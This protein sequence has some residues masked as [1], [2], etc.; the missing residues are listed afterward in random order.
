[1]AIFKLDDKSD[2]IEAVANEEL[3]N[4]NK[5]LLAED[6]LIIAQGKVQNDRFSGGLRM[7]VQ[8]VWSLAAARARFGRHLMLSDAGTAGLIHDLV[9]RFPPRVV[10]TEEGG[11]RKLGLPV[12]VSVLAEP[13]GGQVG[14]RWLVELGETSR[15]WPADEALAKLGAA[16]EVI[17]EV[18]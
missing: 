14:A 11:T 17:Y 5:E 13:Q 3:L 7:N 8:A 6:E 15:F 18:S 12:R 4:A 1:V 16:A 10:E 9:Q 2:A